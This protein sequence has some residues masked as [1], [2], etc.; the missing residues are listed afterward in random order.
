M[1]A[2]HKLLTIYNKFSYMNRKES[3]KR[4]YIAHRKEKIEYQKKYHAANREERNEYMKQ[5]HAANK[6]EHN[7]RCRNTD[8]KRKFGIT[9]EQYSL[10]FDT[11]NGCCKIC[12][13]HRDTFKRTLAVDHNHTTGKIR[14]LL[15][16]DCN[17]GL[18]FFKDNIEILTE[19]INYLKNNDD[20]L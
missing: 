8:L 4:Y 12:G 13:K 19:A 16:T 15:C 3:S 9:Q 18:G 10:I 6:E 2:F 14:G 1:I 17:Q 5:Y 20:K 7:K 11:Q